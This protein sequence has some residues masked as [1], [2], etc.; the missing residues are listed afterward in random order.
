MVRQL[1]RDDSTAEDMVQ[2]TLTEALADDSAGSTNL[3]G[4]L[5]STAR[6]LTSQYWRSSARRD[7]RE[8]RVGLEDEIVLQNSSELTE[9]F[10][11]ANRALHQLPEEERVAVMMRHMQGLKASEV[12]LEMNMPV[13]EV[14]RHTENGTRKLRDRL[15]T[16]YGRDWRSSC[17]AILALPGIKRA[18]VGL[19]PMVASITVGFVLLAG[20]FWALQVD[21]PTPQTSSGKLASLPRGES[22]TDTTGSGALADTAPVRSNLPL[23]SLGSVEVLCQ[24]IGT[25]MLPYASAHVMAFWQN[26][27]REE[28]K[29]IT[30]AAGFLSFVIPADV[31]NL[32]LQFGGFGLFGRTVSVAM[33]NREQLQVLQLV[34]G[35][36]PASFRS[37]HARAGETIEVKGGGDFQ[38]RNE[39]YGLCVTEEGGI[40]PLLLPAPGRYHASGLGA[41]PTWFGS[42]FLVGLEGVQDPIHVAFDVPS[43]F[44]LVAQE[45]ETTM[46]LD[47]AR[48]F[49]THGTGEGFR[50]TP[51][52]SHRGRLHLD[53][54]LPLDPREAVQVQVDGYF[55]SFALIQG[56]VTEEIVL[57]L[58]RKE[59]VEARLHLPSPNRTPVSLI[60]YDS[61]PMIKLPDRL[62][63][64]ELTSRSGIPNPLDIDSEGRFLMP[65]PIDW[66]GDGFRFK[67][68]DDLGETWES[69]FYSPGDREGSELE[70]TLPPKPE[71]MISFSVPGGKP[72][73][74]SVQYL[75]YPVGGGVEPHNPMVPDEAGRLQLETWTGEYTGVQY[76]EP[77]MKMILK[78]RL[79]EGTTSAH[80][81]CGIPDRN[82]SL[83]GQ[84]HG[85]DG[86]LL[87]DGSTFYATYLEPIPV[88]GPGSTEEALLTFIGSIENGHASLEDC[89]EGMYSIGLDFRGLPS[90]HEVDT[91]ES[92]EIRFAANHVIMARVHD[93][94]TGAP[95]DAAL[96]D[97]SIIRSNGMPS[98]YQYAD[99]GC[100]FYSRA[101]SA[102]F[103]RSRLL[104]AKWKY[105]PEMVGLLL[106]GDL[107][108]VRLK[109]G[110]SARVDLEEL[111]LSLIEGNSWIC[112]AWGDVDDPRQPLVSVYG[113]E[114]RNSYA[115][116]AAF[117]FLEVDGDSTETG[118]AIL[119]H[120]DGTAELVEHGA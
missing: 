120:E 102:D 69:D 62:G 119:M 70:F 41:D 13:E 57:P 118:R 37:M 107:T 50:R 40:A 46:L 79:P 23:L 22:T 74:S 31:E 89:P 39:W 104:F 44:T 99:A 97:T 80:F 47:Q 77:G 87:A 12:A 14:Y 85:P 32:K 60:L 94:E 54:E 42:H 33:E 84:I 5:G 64:G 68:V 49:L 115:P 55:D 48:Y 24:V 86:Q 52:S 66:P 29:G 21:D 16:R 61:C 109:P 106:S 82:S 27:Q 19:V 111:G 96:I 88:V 67:V 65:R 95:L 117:H 10:D 4:W 90:V 43:G 11:I 7:R 28:R 93:S 15:E 103:D 3:R 114:I 51:L 25:D 56:S 58:F 113:T 8:H 35:S 1:V 36:I 17:L 76:L 34:E 100:G 20:G 6:R 116:R 18:P 112:D 2:A 72:A 26:S 101:F 75:V 83:S 71:G 92:F 9:M 30:D 38:P 53:E 45:A 98:Q 73:S 91:S 81:E 108:T 59:Q 63:G 105:E 110:R 78:A